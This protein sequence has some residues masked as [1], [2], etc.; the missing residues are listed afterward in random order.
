YPEVPY[1]HKVLGRLAF[2]SGDMDEAIVHFS[3]FLSLV[4]GKEVH[5]FAKSGPGI[6]YEA[7]HMLTKAYFRSK[8]FEEA[9]EHLRKALPI[10]TDL[11]QLH[12]DLG[13]A[14]SRLRRFD[15]AVEHLTEALRIDSEMDGTLNNLAWLKAALKNEG[16]HDPAEAVRLAERA[17]KLTENKRPNFLDTLSVAYASAGRFPEAIKT[18]EKALSLARSAADGTSGQKKLADEIQ[19]HLELFKQGKPFLEP[20]P[21]RTE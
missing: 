20:A 10:G 7:H 13:Y 14:L 11:H 8:R 16:F 9:V 19:V 6:I 2:D 4:T 15:E 17:C 5:R 21:S 3:K 1:F 12:G 18:A